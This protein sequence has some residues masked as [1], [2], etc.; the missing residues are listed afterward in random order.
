MY[1]DTIQTYGSVSVSSWDGVNCE[2]R[3]QLKVAALS[4]IS[5]AGLSHCDWVTI[6]AVSFSTSRRLRACSWLVE[7]SADRDGVELR[8][9]AAVA[10]TRPRRRGL[11]LSL[12]LCVCVCVWFTR[13]V[14]RRRTRTGQDRGRARCISAAVSLRDVS[15]LIELLT[16]V[17]YRAALRLAGARVMCQNVGSSPNG[18]TFLLLPWVLGRVYQKSTGWQ[19]AIAKGRYRR[20]PLSQKSLL[21]CNV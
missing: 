9:T 2:M 10:V 3:S 6:R 7:I 17:A 15:T 13:S 1:E 19:S 14:R 4:E 16:R 8:V 11:S 20:G 5:I 21:P 12:S 18:H